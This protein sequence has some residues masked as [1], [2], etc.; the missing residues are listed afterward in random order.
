MSI[1][2]PARTLVDLVPR[3]SCNAGLQLSVTNCIGTAAR[4]QDQKSISG[5]AAA[6]KAVLDHSATLALCGIAAGHLREEKT[7][8]AEAT[9]KP[10]GRQLRAEV[11]QISGC[12]ENSLENREEDSAKRSLGERGRSVKK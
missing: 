5:A 3:S 4:R 10:A 11:A 12:S 8:V 1:F 6:R 2:S 9:K 7:W